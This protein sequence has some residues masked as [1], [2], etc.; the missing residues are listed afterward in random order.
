MHIDI[1]VALRATTVGVPLVQI[2]LEAVDVHRD[3]LGETREAGEDPDGITLTHHRSF[4]LD[5][6]RTDFGHQGFPLIGSTGKR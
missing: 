3:D 5:T 6:L 1:A 2:A 4:A